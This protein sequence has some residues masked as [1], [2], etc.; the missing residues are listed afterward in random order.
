LNPF[1]LF[2]EIQRRRIILIFSVG[3]IS[4]QYTLER[5]KAERDAMR[6]WEDRGS[7]KTESWKKAASKTYGELEKNPQNKN[8]G[9]VRP[10]WKPKLEDCF[11]QV[12]GKGKK[13]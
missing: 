1:V 3:A 11:P 2:L 6:L 9:L 8:Q 4:T 7:H 13:V 10:K 5:E 12:R